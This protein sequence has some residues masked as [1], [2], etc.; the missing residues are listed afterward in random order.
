M[1]R[2]RA[3]KHTVGHTAQRRSVF[4]SCLSEMGK[5]Y[6]PLCIAED[7]LL[8]AQILPRSIYNVTG[9]S[10]TQGGGLKLSCPSYGPSLGRLAGSFHFSREG[11]GVVDPATLSLSVLFFFFLLFKSKLPASW[12][13]GTSSGEQGPASRGCS[14]AQPCGRFRKETCS[15]PGFLPLPGVDGWDRSAGGGARLPL[16]PSKKGGL[17][18]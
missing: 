6:I 14:S 9:A 13:P 11:Y 2:R 10:K 3:D 16:C 1:Q 18:L 8:V 15:R 17:W 12:H 4:L 5:C 7:M